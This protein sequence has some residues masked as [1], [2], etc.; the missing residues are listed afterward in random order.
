MRRVVPAVVALVATAAWSADR[1]PA[2]EDP[3]GDWVTR[4]P[5]A[6][7]LVALPDLTDAA[8]NNRRVP[9]KVHLPAGDGPFAIVLVSHGAGG[10][11]DTH[12]AQAQ[13][14]ASHGYA[15]LCL[16]HVGSNAERLKDSR[17]PLPDLLAMTTDATEVLGRPR[18]VRFVLD[19]AA[20]WQRTHAK[21][22][23][24]LDLQRVALMGHSFGA[25]T[26]MMVCGMRPALDWLRPTVPPGKGLGPDLRDPRVKCGVALSPQG[27]GEPFF[28]KES[29]AS[30]A[31][32]LLGV[33]GSQDRQQGNLPAENRR[34]AFTLWPAGPH[35]LVW[36]ANAKHLDFCDS[37]GLA[38]RM[39]P[40]AT[41]RDVQDICRVATLFFLNGQ[42][43]G[44]AEAAARLTSDGLAPWAGGAV[45][46]I[47]VL[48]R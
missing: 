35:K 16:E 28:I 39:L 27:V 23:G 1:A 14:L 17:R 8:R 12:Y 34:Q 15:V 29:F 44:D 48:S 21:L 46:K 2:F 20:E 3:R 37:T 11:W 4:G 5:L 7:E 42:L 45:S 25:A 6:V 18:D 41:R 32:P 24:K 26:T 36:L 30:L 10:D 33:S 19:R 40:S 47:E 13:H 38:R 9:V 22:R 31:V 43:K